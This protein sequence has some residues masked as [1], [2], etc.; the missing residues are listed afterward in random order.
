MNATAHLT[1]RMAGYF[2]DEKNEEKFAAPDTAEARDAFWLETLHLAMVELCAELKSENLKVRSK[3]AHKIIDLER[4]KLRHAKKSSLAGRAGDGSS[5]LSARSATHGQIDN[6]LGFCSEG[7]VGVSPAWKGRDPGDGKTSSEG[8]SE[9]SIAPSE[10]REIVAD[11][12][13]ALPGRANAGGSFGAKGKKNEVTQSTAVTD[14]CDE[15]P[16]LA[17]PANK[18]AEIEAGAID[19]LSLDIQTMTTMFAEKLQLKN[20]SMTT[21][22]AARA[23]I[24]RYMRANEVTALKID[25]HDIA[26][27]VMNMMADYKEHEAAAEANREENTPSFVEAEGS[28]AAAS[29]KSFW[30]R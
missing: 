14:G 17:L 20:R 4:T 21:P 28:P 1:N 9:A 7:A 13:P 15:D 29:G 6:A 24:A 18:M 23:I 3:A 25:P 8:A 12:D 19:M 10:L 5:H 11:H 16:S 22:E 30:Q 26:L 2:L 27:V